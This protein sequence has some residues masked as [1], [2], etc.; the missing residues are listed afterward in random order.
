M[1]GFI[2]LFVFLLIFIIINVKLVVDREVF[3]VLC[4]IFRSNS[5]E[6]DIGNTGKPVWHLKLPLFPWLVYLHIIKYV[7][8]T[9][10]HLF[11]VGCQPGM[12]SGCWQTSR[13]TT[14]LLI[15]KSSNMNPY[16]LSTGNGEFQL[17]TQKDLYKVRVNWRE[18][19]KSTLSSPV[20]FLL[21]FQAL[22]SLVSILRVSFKN[23]NT[24]K[25]FS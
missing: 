14:I 2:Y 1:A 12:L 13:K 15:G 18:K 9:L 25:E 24:P 7:T 23:P 6:L 19:I 22:P 20:L 11:L 16:Q 8:K 5:W 3:S 4:S 21:R 17:L 10:H